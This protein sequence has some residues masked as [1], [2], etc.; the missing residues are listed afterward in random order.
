MLPNTTKKHPNLKGFGDV[1]T[2]LP[3][4][5]TQYFNHVFQTVGSCC[6]SIDVKRI[7][8]VCEVCYAVLFFLYCCKFSNILILTLT[9]VVMMDIVSCT[10]QPNKV[11]V[12]VLQILDF[13]TANS[14]RKLVNYCPDCNIV[15]IGVPIFISRQVVAEYNQP[16]SLGYLPPSF[17]TSDFF[18]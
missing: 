18:H 7:R 10:S 16:I 13:Q 2:I 17:F 9:N 4:V 11:P 3:L 15:S 12:H 8:N 14:M 5:K 1:W 6:T